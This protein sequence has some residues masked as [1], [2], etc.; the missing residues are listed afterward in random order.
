MD[1]KSEGPKVVPSE[2]FPLRG[3]RIG[4]DES[5]MEKLRTQLATATTPEE[6]KSIEKQ[7]AELV[8]KN[9]SSQG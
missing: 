4:G 5:Q 1:D 8:V 9:L 2:A 7:M 6:K 3:I